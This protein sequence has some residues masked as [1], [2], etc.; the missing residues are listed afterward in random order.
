M[1][2]PC[3]FLGGS[4][5]GAVVFPCAPRLAPFAPALRNA[6]TAAG[7]SRLLR[8]FSRRLRESIVNNTKSADILPPRSVGRIVCAPL[9][10][11]LLA[12]CCVRF[13]ADYVFLRFRVVLASCSR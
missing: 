3:L 2:K 10:R 12:P 8:Q 11:R 6:R 7:R 1:F 4:R 5:V 9:P 13:P